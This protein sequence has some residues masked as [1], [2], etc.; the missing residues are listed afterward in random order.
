MKSDE[1]FILLDKMIKN[2]KDGKYTFKF[3]NI[4]FHYT[5]LKKHL[6]D[7][8]I[9]TEDV[10]EKESIAASI[11]EYCDQENELCCGVHLGNLSLAYKRYKYS[12]LE[13]IGCNK[14]GFVELLIYIALYIFRKEAIC[15]SVLTTSDAAQKGDNY[16]SVYNARKWLSKGLDIQTIIDNQNL[17]PIC[18]YER[19][20]FVFDEKYFKKRLLEFIIKDNKKVDKGS[21][22]R[23]NQFF[24]KN[25][26]LSQGYWLPIPLNELKK[27]IINQIKIHLN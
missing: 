25:I 19:Y 23:Q 1:L 5:I 18:Y 8:Q 2:K 27:M 6:D 20:N 3:K 15:K 22:K 26:I 4:V 11:Q 14:K 13:Q 16:I 9:L 7:V 21:I 17:Y 12:Y 10:R 24:K